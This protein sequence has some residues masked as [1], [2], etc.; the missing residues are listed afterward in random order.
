[1]II[2]IFIISFVSWCLMSYRVIYITDNKFNKA[3][4]ISFLEEIFGVVVV[5]LIIINHLNIWYLLMAGLGAYCGTRFDV[6]DF[7]KKFKQKL[8]II[9]FLK[10]PFRNKCQYYQPEGF[11]CNHPTA[12]DGYCGE[13]KK[14]TN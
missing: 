8:K 7:I 1:M 2:L 12:E 3:G 11:T 4:L 13:Y 10:C 5:S 14:L 9:F 6:G